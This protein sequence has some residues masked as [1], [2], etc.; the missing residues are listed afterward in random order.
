MAYWYTGSAFHQIPQS[1]NHI[2]RIVEEQIL[3]KHNI[4]WIIESYWE[5]SSFK[6]AEESNFKEAIYGREMHSVRN[7]F[8]ST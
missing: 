5:H 2:I 6:S 3:L 4:K 8:I 7:N 1:I